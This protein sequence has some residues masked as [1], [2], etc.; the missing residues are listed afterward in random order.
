M[1]PQPGGGG[2]AGRRSAAVLALCRA[3]TRISDE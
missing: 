1:H 3:H 2:E